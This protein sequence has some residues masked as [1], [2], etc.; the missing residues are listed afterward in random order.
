M[1]K[2]NTVPAFSTHNTIFQNKENSHAVP[3]TVKG[4]LPAAPVRKGA[5]PRQRTR[6]PAVP[7][8]SQRGVPLPVP[9]L[10]LAFVC[11]SVRQGCLL[12]PS[13]RVS[14][15]LRWCGLIPMDLESSWRRYPGWFLIAGGASL[16]LL[17]GLLVLL[18]GQWLLECRPS[19]VN[20][21]GSA[22]N[23]TPEFQPAP[24]TQPASQPAPR[25]NGSESRFLIEPYAVGPMRW[26]HLSRYLKAGYSLDGAIAVSP[27]F[28][29]SS[30]RQQMLHSG[31]PGRL[32]RSSNTP[33]PEQHKQTSSRSQD[34]PAN[35]AHFMALDKYPVANR[36]VL[37]IGSFRP[38]V[39]AICLSY[40][41]SLVTSVHYDA[42]T[43]SYPKLRVISLPELD[44]SGQKFDAVFSY[45]SLEH[46]GLGRYGDPLNP[47]ADLKRMEA[48]KDVLKPGGKLF[49]GVPNGN[50][51]LGTMQRRVSRAHTFPATYQGM[52][53]SGKRL[54][55]SLEDCFNLPHL[56]QL[57]APACVNPPLVAKPG[58]P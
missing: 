17:G 27:W 6:R 31:P 50:D 57:N 43:V 25:T 24:S 56:E 47:E 36:S 35:S 29:D 41:A 28:I 34:F 19:T 37:V 18:A 4:T 46:D 3:P 45:S 11:S 33:T 48:I 9:R 10:A 30:A 55:T 42:P 22:F 38:W 40:G 44:A 53:S 7:T 13:S 21:A 14:E 32:R 49:L 58:H 52:E 1:T 39:E 2:P 20:L 23:A 12:Q 51:T 26:E 5:R 8:S 16:P 54:S 15:L